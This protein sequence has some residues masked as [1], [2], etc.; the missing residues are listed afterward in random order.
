LFNPSYYDGIVFQAVL[1]T[2]GNHADIIAA[3]ITAILLT[4]VDDLYFIGGRYDKLVKEFLP[5]KASLSCAAVGVSIAFEKILSLVVAY[6][7]KIIKKSVHVKLR[8]S[9]TEVF[10]CSVGRG[11][12]E[13]RMQIANELWAL[14]IRV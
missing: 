8:T 12:L 11:L 3:G 4:S 7:L 1:D 10:V 6:E 2:E 5:P 9:E 13:E 14:D